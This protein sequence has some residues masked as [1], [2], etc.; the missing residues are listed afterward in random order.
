MKIISLVQNLIILISGS[1]APTALGSILIAIL[2]D[3]PLAFISSVL[4]S[5]M[6][7][8]IFNTE[9]DAAF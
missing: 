2:L 1:L 5:I 6:A 4:F 9:H 8:I 3:A 7:S